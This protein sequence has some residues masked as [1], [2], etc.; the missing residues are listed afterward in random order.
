MDF[1][2]LRSKWIGWAAGIIIAV[3]I[4]ALLA[5]IAD[6]QPATVQRSDLEPGDSEMLRARVVQVLQEGTI[7]HGDLQQP[8]QRLRIRITEG[9]LAGQK[10]D[11]E[12]GD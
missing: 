5:G 2:F 6:Q 1:S 9:G 8:Y 11:L 10:V 12:Y 3:A 4:F 7:A